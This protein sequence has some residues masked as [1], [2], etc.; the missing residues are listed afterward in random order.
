MFEKAL[1]IYPVAKSEM[2]HIGDSYSNDYKP[3]NEFGIHALVYNPN[4]MELPE[5]TKQLSILSDLS[6][7]L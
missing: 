4:Q 2:L 6:H 1:E 5:G 3:A 7:L